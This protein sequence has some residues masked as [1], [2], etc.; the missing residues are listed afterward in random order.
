M[1][2]ATICW[3]N[4]RF[5]EMLDK[6]TLTHPWLQCIPSHFSCNVSR[7]RSRFLRFLKAHYFVDLFII[8]LF[9]CRFHGLFR[10]CRYKSYFCFNSY[11]RQESFKF[12]NSRE[13]YHIYMQFLVV[14]FL[15][16]YFYNIIILLS[17]TASV[18]LGFYRNFFFVLKMPTKIILK[19]FSV[20]CFRTFE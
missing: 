19:N 1:A 3:G 13:E 11:F 6:M 20:H 4:M 15:N 17:L 9:T 16:T 10:M 8:I 2:C 18:L 12:S 5:R 7:S 14:C